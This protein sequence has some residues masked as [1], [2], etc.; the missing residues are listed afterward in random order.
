MHS[1]RQG[2]DELKEQKV[3]IIAGMHRSG[4]S[5]V[6]SILQAAGV[7]IGDEL[8]GPA[9]GNPRGHFEDAD[10]FQFHEKILRRFG[11]SFL[12]QSTAAL[13]DITLAERDEAV[14][15][16]KQRKPCRGVAGPRENR[17]AKI[18]SPA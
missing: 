4:T 16:I 2:E 5:L 1:L 12:I 9:P 15:L 6:S 13:G 7:D 17:T 18:T 3:I 14:A 10:F 8:I 11:Q